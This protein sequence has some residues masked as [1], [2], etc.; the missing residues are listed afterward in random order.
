V[1]PLIYGYVRVEDGSSEDDIQQAEQRMKHLA[2]AEGF[3]YERTF[4]EYVSGDRSA[5][6]ELIAEIQRVEA[7]AVIVPSHAHLSAHPILFQIM[8]ERL[9]K[10]ALA[11]LWAVEGDALTGQDDCT[12]QLGADDA[13]SGGI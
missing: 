6:E 10:E 12:F 2:R 13:T 3:C 1:K 9:A 7:R 4:Y 5:F 11:C 8:V